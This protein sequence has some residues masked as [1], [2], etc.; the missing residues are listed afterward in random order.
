MIDRGQAR[1]RRPP[2]R[3]RAPRRAAVSP[4]RGSKDMRMFSLP[5]G[6]WFVLGAIVGAALAAGAVAVAAIP[7]SAGVI[8]GCYQKNVGNLRVLDPAAG[9][10][11]RPSEVEISWSR[12]G[13][14]GLQ[15]IQ[16]IQGPKGDKGD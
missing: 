4:G 12:T 16:G 5:R 6:R 13:P 2:M 10:S 7:D 14:Q 8:H 11:C 1:R 15:G 9:D 3:I